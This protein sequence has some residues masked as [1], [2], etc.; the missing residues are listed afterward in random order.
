MM[1]T[2]ESVRKSYGKTVRWFRNKFS[3]STL[4]CNDILWDLSLCIQPSD[5]AQWICVSGLIASMVESEAFC[6]T[7]GRCWGMPHGLHTTY[8]TNGQVYR[9]T[10][11]KRGRRHG[12]RKLYHLNGEIKHE[13]DYIG[14]Y[15]HGKL[16]QYDESGQETY[17]AHFKNGKLDGKRILYHENGQIKSKQDFHRGICQNTILYDETGEI[18]YTY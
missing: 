12:K 2:V 15:Y 4:P 9:E 3:M 6:R 16:V 13:E 14:G 11:Y 8:Y 1:Y 17:K 5:L 18:T 10:N 7:Y